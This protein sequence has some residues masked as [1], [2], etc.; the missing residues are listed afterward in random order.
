MAVPVFYGKK[1]FLDRSGIALALGSVSY[2]VPG[3][4]TPK[5]TWQDAGAT[6]LNSTTITLDS[7]GYAQVY[8][9]GLY[10][11]IVKDAL[12]NTIWDQ[13]AD[14]SDYAT[15]TAAL[16][17]SGGSNTIGYTEGGTS[18]IATTVQTRLRDIVDAV[19]DYGCDNT[20]ATN[21]TTALKAFYDRCIATG[22]LGFIPAGTYKVTPGVLSF[23]CGSTD[24]A[25][26]NI[27]TAGHEATIFQVDSANDA[28]AAVIAWSNGTEFAFWQGGS[29]GGITVEGVGSGAAKTSQHH[30]SFQGICRARFGWLQSTNSK[31]SAFHLPQKLTGT[32]PDGW[33]CSFLQFQGIE[34]NSP[35]GYLL[36]NENYVGMDS[37]EVF[38]WRCK[39]ALTGVWKGIGSGNVIWNGSVQNSFGWL[40]DDGTNADATGGSP[41]RNYFFIA[42]GDN[43]QNGIRLNRSSRTE[44]IGFRMPSRFQTAPNTDA[45][46]WPRTYIDLGGGAGPAVQEIKIDML[47]R[48]ESGGASGDLGTWC[49]LHS[50]GN[51]GGVE[52]ISQFL[53]NGGLG[54]GASFLRAINVNAAT[55]FTNAMGSTNLLIQDQSD[56]PVS[57]AIGS[58][59]T[60]SIPNTGFGGTTGIVFGSERFFPATAC[61]DT[62][63]YTYTAQRS[64][65]HMVT[66][67]YAI[68]AAAGTRVR[69]AVKTSANGVELLAMQY[70]EPGAVSQ[71]FG[72]Y[73]VVMLTAGDTMFV[74]ADQNTATAAIACDVVDNS[75]EIQFVVVPL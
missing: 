61:Y 4:L 22:K 41:Q 58:A 16:A 56:R 60:T 32:D 66:V 23:V 73:G 5:S 17:A 25:W 21:T 37:W 7:A 39:G 30:F 31:A 43:I 62:T 74:T 67:K 64:G 36:L 49:N 1:Q 8:G 11:E 65:P 24:Q 69:T 38:N 12:G 18:S 13:E 40:F 55:A 54:V 6:T 46:Y 72:T 63:T 19:A 29:H 51:V 68:T 10:R 9:S 34:A 14:A 70:A 52:L 59:A 53:D 27:Y 33:A 75:N 48:L 3:T 42:E 20:G 47:A 28:D 26:P 45:N 44:F 2:Y 71:S 15:L 50:T 57:D 35:A